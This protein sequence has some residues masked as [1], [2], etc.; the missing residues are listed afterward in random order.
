MSVLFYLMFLEDSYF[1]A[2]DALVFFSFVFFN[3]DVLP[4]VRFVGKKVLT[5]EKDRAASKN[6][7]EGRSV[8]NTCPELFLSSQ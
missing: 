8:R 7:E 1:R 4:F 2:E 6:T 5:A 3:S